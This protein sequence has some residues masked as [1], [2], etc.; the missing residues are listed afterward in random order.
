MIKFFRKRAKNSPS[1]L[2]SGEVDFSLMTKEEIAAYYE[3]KMQQQAE[4]QTKIIQNL[5]G[6]LSKSTEKLQKQ[7]KS[8][9]LYKNLLQRYSNN[10]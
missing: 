7:Q 5:R 3:K 9:W 1:G 10:L 4:N 2:K 8:S 6:E